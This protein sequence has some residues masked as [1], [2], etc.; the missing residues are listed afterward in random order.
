MS[1]M[2][3][4]LAGLMLIVGCQQISMTQAAAGQVPENTDQLVKTVA[5][6]VEIMPEEQLELNEHLL[7]TDQNINARA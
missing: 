4:Y 5:A 7:L 6:P 3:L 1:V 2:R